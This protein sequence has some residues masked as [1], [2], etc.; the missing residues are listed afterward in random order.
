VKNPVDR[1][2]TAL[3]VAAV[4]LQAA[5]GAMFIIGKQLE[6]PDNDRN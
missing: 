2:R 6:V 1:R 5:S 4:S 3:A